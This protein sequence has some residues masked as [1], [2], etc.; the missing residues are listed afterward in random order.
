MTATTAPSAQVET[1]TFAQGYARL[2]TERNEGR[3][4]PEAPTMMKRGEYHFATSVFQPRTFEGT[5]DESIEHRDELYE[6]LLRG[7]K[8][9]PLVLW[10]SG[11]RFYIIDGHHRAMAI[12]DLARDFEAGKLKASEPPTVLREGTAV[13]V[14]VGALPEAMAAAVAFNSRN[15]LAMSKD[16]KT[17]RAW[18]LVTLEDAALSKAKIAA[19]AGVSERT[20]ANMRERLKEFGND[21]PDTDPKS[22]TWRDVKEGKVMPAKGDDW[23]D[24]QGKAWGKKLGRVFGKKPAEMPDVFLLAI[25]YYST[26]LYSRMAEEFEREVNSDF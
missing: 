10:W 23:R 20:V 14:F 13:E 5:E 26:R 4:Q 6:A 22:L 11:Q 18:K 17:E 8:F 19:A 12:A 15:K 21:Y 7:D 3:P 25:H 24:K 16:D 2:L 1:P 9:P